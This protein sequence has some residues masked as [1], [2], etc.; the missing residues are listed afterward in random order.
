MLGSMNLAWMLGTVEPLKGRLWVVW[1]RR[2]THTILTLFLTECL[3]RSGDAWIYWN[4][5]EQLC[6]VRELLVACN[7]GISG[8]LDAA[9]EG[10]GT[11]CHLSYRVSEFFYVPTPK[12]PPPE[13]R[14][15]Q[16]PGQKSSSSG[17]STISLSWGDA[18][19]REAR[20]PWEILWWGQIPRKERWQRLWVMA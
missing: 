11:E 13:L 7:V 14:R 6:N 15:D 2:W 3:P 4:S 16:R 5:V 18:W 12:L 8:S 1:C 9:V 20:S 19:A 10:T 17:L